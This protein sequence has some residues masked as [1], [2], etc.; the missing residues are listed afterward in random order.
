M[1]TTVLAWSIWLD[2]ESTRRWLALTA[3]VAAGVWFSYPLV[4]VAAGVGTVLA[5]RVGDD[6]GRRA[7]GPARRRSA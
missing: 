4:F 1:M 5:V 7:V 2:R 3:L 6:P